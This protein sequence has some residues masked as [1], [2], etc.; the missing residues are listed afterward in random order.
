MTY[1]GDR[2]PR[3]PKPLE[4]QHGTRQPLHGVMVLLHDVIEIFRVT[5]DNRGFVKLVV[6]FDRRGV[7]ATLIDRD[8]LW[9]SLMRMAL[10]GKSCDTTRRAL[11]GSLL[12][13]GLGE[14]FHRVLLLVTVYPAA[15][16]TLM[17]EVLLRP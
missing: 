13:P 7:A 2:T 14:R 10:R 3:R 4:P 1:A 12:S 15:G 8:F 11:R 5:D 9:Q 16:S 6:A 17:K